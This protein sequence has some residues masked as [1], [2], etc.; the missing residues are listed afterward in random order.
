MR[1]RRSF[2]S[3]RHARHLGLA[4]VLTL[5][6]KAIQQD[7]DIRQLVIGICIAF[8]AITVVAAFAAILGGD[9]DRR[10]TAAAV[11]ATGAVATIIVILIL[12]ARC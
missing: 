10:S 5:G 4:L 7:Q 2:S 1:P 8:A 12:V 3:S 11:T 6:C 9:S